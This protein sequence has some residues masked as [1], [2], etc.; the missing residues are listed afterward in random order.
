MIVE[1]YYP[2]IGGLD[3]ILLGR[4][5]EYLVDATAAFGRW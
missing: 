2:R 3:Q 5:R 1:R 4:R